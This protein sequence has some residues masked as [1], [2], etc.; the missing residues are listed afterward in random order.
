MVNEDIPNTPFFGA[1][2]NGV[3]KNYEPVKGSKFEVSTNKLILA[4]DFDGTIVEDQFP[5]VGKP[6][7]K[8]FESLIELKG[9][10]VKLILWTCR[11]NEYLTDAVNFCEHYGLKF[12]YVNSPVPD[13]RFD[14]EKRSPKPFAHIYL[15]D[16]SYPGFSGWESFM[17]DFRRSYNIIK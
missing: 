10:G 16:R 5:Y 15:D 6:L 11:S 7:P 9:Y 2:V 13:K 12:D 17:D 8:S 1:I 14:K 3:Q 4:I